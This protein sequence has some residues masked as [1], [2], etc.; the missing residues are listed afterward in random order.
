MLRQ[1][2]PRCSRA[3]PLATRPLRAA[4]RAYSSGV[5][6][7]AAA[8]SKLPG[9]DPSKLIVNTTTTPKPLV[10]PAKLV[11]GKEFSGKPSSPAV[12]LAVQL[13]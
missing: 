8:I 12:R 1:L 3:L 6:P 7:D 5:R 13:C 4:P 10:D 9:L 11:F 2:L